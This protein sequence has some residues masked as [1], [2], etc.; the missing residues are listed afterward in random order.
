MKKDQKVLSAKK[1]YGSDFLAA[2][3]I[4]KEKQ[5]GGGYNPERYEKT[6]YSRTGMRGISDRSMSGTGKRNGKDPEGKCE[7]PH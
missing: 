2:A 7:I 6:D 1:I 3:D 5:E 4:L